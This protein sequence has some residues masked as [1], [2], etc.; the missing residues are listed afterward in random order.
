M[1]IHVTNLHP[2]GPGSLSWALEHIIGRVGATIVF[3]IPWS[4]AL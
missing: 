3:D 4:G 2:R 1:T